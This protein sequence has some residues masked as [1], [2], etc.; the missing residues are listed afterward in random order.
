MKPCF[1]SLFKR[2]K[3][4]CGPRPSALI[5]NNATDAAQEKESKAAERY[6]VTALAF[7]LRYDR[8]FC[9]G[10]FIKHFWQKVCR[11]KSDPPLGKN[12]EIDVEKFGWADLLIVNTVA[13]R[14]F[15]YVIECKINARLADKQNPSSI[16]FEAPGG[17]GHLIGKWWKKKDKL[18][19]I[20][21][22]QRPSTN[23]PR[24]NSRILIQQRPW[25]DLEAACPTN[26]LTEDLF[27][28]L[29][30]LGI[31]VFNHRRTNTMKIGNLRQ[32]G[33]ACEILKHTRE[34]LGFTRGHCKLDV[35]AEPD[36]WC[37]AMNV[38]RPP[39][40][41]GSS[42]NHRK[43]AKL[44]NPPKRWVAWFG[45]AT[46]GLDGQE[47]QVYLYCKEK[48]TAKRLQQRLEKRSYAVKYE[49]P[50]PHW[51]SVIVKTRKHKLLGDRE[52]FL[53][54]FEAVGLKRAA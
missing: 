27:N 50:E 29:G 37:F 15:V 45:Y 40:S 26:A 17:Y 2:G 53:S 36:Y 39:K 21:L 30:T 8:E 52:W 48:L 42:E 47:L 1:L 31:A 46:D 4:Y 6:A 19:Y 35:S 16:A 3:Y 5:E 44:L 34:K 24:R 9:G 22:Q 41:R 43:L 10:K 28:C 38:T 25:T 12:P 54:V 7:R 23:R 18:R 33:A 32:A 13:T 14:R 11:A 49:N 20:L 51:H